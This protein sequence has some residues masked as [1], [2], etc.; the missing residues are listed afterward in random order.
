MPPK[1]KA[2]RTTKSQTS[3]SGSARDPKQ[4]D[5]KQTSPAV[6]N[7][8]SPGS[9]S[10]PF[11]PEVEEWRKGRSLKQ[12]HEYMLTNQVAC[13]VFFTVGVNEDK[14]GAHKYKLLAVSDVFYV[15]LL[16][17][18]AEH[19]NTIK[20]PDID[21]TS[22]K[23]FLRYV[24]TEELD[25][26]PDTVMQLMYVAKK[27][28]V[29]P[30]VT[31]IISY[32]DAQMSIES[33]CVVMEQA[34][35]F[36][37]PTLETKALEFIEDHATSVLE[38][39][40]V[41]TL[42]AA[43]L[44]TVVSSDNL[45]VKLGVRRELWEMERKA[46]AADLEKS[47]LTAVMT[48][49]THQCVETKVKVTGQ[50]QRKVLGDIL[51]EVRFSQLSPDYFVADVTKMNILSSEE[52]CMILE[53][54]VAPNK[55]KSKL[56]N[57]KRRGPHENIRTVTRFRN[58]SEDTCIKNDYHHAVSFKTNED[59]YLHGFCLF[60]TSTGKTCLYDVHSAV[61]KD[62]EVICELNTK[63]YDKIEQLDIW[64]KR[65]SV[66]RRTTEEMFRVYFRRKLL[67]KKDTMHTLYVDLKGPQ[68]YTGL[69][70]RSEICFY[71]DGFV[72]IT[73]QDAPD[74]NDAKSQTTSL[75]GQIPSLLV[76]LIP[77]SKPITFK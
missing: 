3:A 22:F 46:A 63:V 52:R 44:K 67:I 35:L 32:I 59:L 54:V 58:T 13:D 21:L 9:S 8:S 14:Y 18:M 68:C 71:T 2:R 41:T 28:N 37:E 55:A 33:A 42:C 43:C 30:L 23:A 62:K 40:E 56:C 61:Y 17:P 38:S 66:H 26:T 48:W 36:N 45:H 4:S 64:M 16:G 50:N 39:K 7:N 65:K 57:M 24:Y 25:V 27:Y 51:W 5:E 73:F 75:K 53:H 31:A 20:I 19:D 11:I 34:H 6:T 69:E 1:R 49:A 70:G 76:S 12:C 15:M 74:F 72:K 77:C 60:G 29:E 10:I 47:V